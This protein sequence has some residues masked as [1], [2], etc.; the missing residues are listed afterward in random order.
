[1]KYED[2]IDDCTIQQVFVRMSYYELLALE[3][4]IDYAVN[5]LDEHT[6]CQYTDCFFD[7]ISTRSKEDMCVREALIE[8]RDSMRHI[9]MKYLANFDGFELPLKSK[10]WDYSLGDEYDEY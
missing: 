3:G 8:V 10:E 6:L 7:D 4:C 2:S 1:M 5:H 9:I